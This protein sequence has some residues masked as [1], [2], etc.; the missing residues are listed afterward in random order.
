MSDKEEEHCGLDFVRRIVE[1][2]LKSNKWGGRVATRFPPEPNGY[3]HIGHAKS[4]CLNFG[5]AQEYDGR[6]NLRFDDTNPTTEDVRYVDSIQQDV[7]WLGFEWDG[8]FYA[9]DY[10]D[11]LYD[12]AEKLVRKGRAYVDSQS[13]EEIRLNRGTVT[14]PGVESPYRSRSVE[15]NL[16]LLRRMKA[17]EFSDG[18][19]VLRA[20]IDMAHPNMIMRDTLLLR[21]R[22]FHHYR[23]GDRWCVYPLYDFAHGLSDAFEGITRSLCTLEFKGNRDIY[24]WLVH[25]AGLENPPTQIEVARLQLEVTLVSHRKLPRPVNDRPVTSSGHPP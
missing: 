20:K 1:E 6:C 4:I 18:A 10:F 21:I 23:Q 22:H 11:K 9:S 24:D 15:E 17:G 7:R 16:D 19:H 14:T 13:D 25:E 3:L 2:D 8:L 5:I 12:V